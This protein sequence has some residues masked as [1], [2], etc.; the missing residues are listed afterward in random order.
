MPSDYDRLSFSIPKNVKNLLDALADRLVLEGKVKSKSA[1]LAR[2]VEE[3]VLDAFERGEI[4][5]Q[6]VDPEELTFTVILET[7]EQKQQLEELARKDRRTPTEML[8]NI[9]YSVFEHYDELSEISEIDYR[10]FTDSIRL[11]LKNGEL[12]QLVIQFLT[13]LKQGNLPPDDQC[14]RIAS[15]LEWEPEEVFLIRDR[16][17]KRDNGDTNRVKPSLT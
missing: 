1:L 3:Y 11:L 9:V 6:Q 12:S 10:S 17:S 15:L 2:L 4:V 5:L 16:C 13:Y 14:I 7:I 8:S